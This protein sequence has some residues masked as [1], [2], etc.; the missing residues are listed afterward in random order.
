MRTYCAEVLRSNTCGDEEVA[1]RKFPHDQIS[2]DWITAVKESNSSKE[3]LQA[4]KSKRAMLEA[5]PRQ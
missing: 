3:K 2:A 5:L 4:Y 1:F